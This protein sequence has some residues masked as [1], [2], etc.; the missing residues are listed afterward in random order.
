MPTVLQIHG[1]RFYFNSNEESR[2]HI[3]VKRQNGKAKFW[4]EPAVEQAAGRG[5]N[6]SELGEIRRII[7]DHHHEIVSAW[8]KHFSR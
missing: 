2:V 1:Y 4:L 6:Q 7:E 3:H 5:F 8:E